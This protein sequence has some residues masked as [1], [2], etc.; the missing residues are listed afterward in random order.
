M[1][2]LLEM[3][4]LCGD[5]PACENFGVCYEYQV[6]EPHTSTKYRVQCI[7]PIHW[8]LVLLAVLI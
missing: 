1:D 4:K 6:C 3:G 2:C 8:S 7:G 5:R